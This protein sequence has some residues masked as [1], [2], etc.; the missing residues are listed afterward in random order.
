MRITINLL[1]ASL[2]AGDSG[3]SK[4]DRVLVKV[5]NNEWYAGTVTRAGAKVAVDFDSGDSVTIGP[6]SF[7]DIKSVPKLK[8]RKASMTNAEAKVTLAAKR[9]SDKQD[10][11]R[12][13][14]ERAMT[15]PKVV[16]GHKVPRV[17]DSNS[18]TPKTDNIVH[19]GYWASN[20]S[21]ATKDK[22][23]PIADQGGRLPAGFKEMTKALRMKKDRGFSI[24]R[25]CKK[26]NG[27]GTY[28]HRSQTTGKTYRM[29]EG[30]AHYISAHKV[31]VPPQ[32]R[33]MLAAF[34][35]DQGTSTAK[36]PKA[37]KPA[38]V[39]TTGR[40]REGFYYS[41]AQ[42]NLPMPVARA[43]KW[44][45]QDAFVAKLK[46]VQG[47]GTP[48]RTKGLAPCRI[49]KKG[50]GSGTYSKG[51]WSWPEGFIH[52]VVDHNVKPKQAFIDFIM[53]R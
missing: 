40:M 53:N 39:E 23:F 9:H 34:K 29:P 6:T 18:P 2:S 27:Y 30:F 21:T 31:A 20:K 44:P 51:K 1:Q 28:I 33:E 49:C 35:A 32:L 16:R 19:V 52:Y 7:K 41:K 12:A 26:Q 17:G 8:K 36:K 25:I 3:F 43:K 15:K 22:P 4:N 50:N 10:K 45:G 14:V 47:R 37:V 46:K 11:V 13:R 42:P 48:G 5:K 24:C 38:P